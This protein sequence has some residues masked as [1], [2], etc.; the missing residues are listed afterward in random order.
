MRHTAKPSPDNLFIY[1]L[2]ELQIIQKNKNILT[3]AIFVLYIINIKYKLTVHFKQ[4][5]FVQM[6]NK[7]NNRYLQ[8]H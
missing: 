5:C 2:K 8:L 6:R 4:L 1:K 7:T 3:L